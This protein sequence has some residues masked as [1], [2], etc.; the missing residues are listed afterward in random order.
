MTRPLL[1]AIL[2]AACATERPVHPFR[3]EGFPGAPVEGDLFPRFEVARWVFRDRI[4]PGSPDLVLAMRR[5]GGA[6]RLTGTR[7]G[8]AELRFEAGF[9]EIRAGGETVDRI[10]KLEGRMGDHWG[11]GGSDGLATL[12]GYDRLTV[13]GESRRALVVAVDRPPLRDLYWFADGLGWVRIR[14]ERRGKAVRDAG[15]VGFEAKGPGI[16]GGPRRG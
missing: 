6:F 1:L 14:T 10:L 15:L 3:L 4:D 13:L 11:S 8:E 12:F 16:D 2:L 9:V 5:E 7:E